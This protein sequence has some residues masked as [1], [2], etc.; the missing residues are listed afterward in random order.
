M[1]DWTAAVGQLQPFMFMDTRTLLLHLEQ[2]LESYTGSAPVVQVV[3]A[4]LDYETSAGPAWQSDGWNK[5][6][7]SMPTSSER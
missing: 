3:V 6:H 4:G 7:P 5:G 2:P 1:T